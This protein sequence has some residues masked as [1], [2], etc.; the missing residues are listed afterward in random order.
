MFVFQL[1]CSFKRN[2]LC[3]LRASPQVHRATKTMPPGSLLAWFD[4]LS[5]GRRAID[6]C[7]KQIITAS[8]TTFPADHTAASLQLFFCCC[9][10]GSWKMTNK[11]PQIYLKRFAVHKRASQSAISPKVIR[12]GLHNLWVAYSSLPTAHTLSMT[13]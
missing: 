1:S 3:K 11:T 2:I 5:G 13:F 10:D 4:F 8:S 6:V 7:S 12:L 9:N